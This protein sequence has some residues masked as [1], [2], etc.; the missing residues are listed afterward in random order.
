MASRAHLDHD[1]LGQVAVVTGGANGIGFG[2][3]KRLAQEGA[4]VAL[5]DMN[6]EQLQVAAERLAASGVKQNHILT[7]AVNVTHE[8]AVNAAVATVLARFGRVDIL[9]QAAGIT[10]VTGIQTHQVCVALPPSSSFRFRLRLL[11]AFPEREW[12]T[13]AEAVVRGLRE[14]RARANT[15]VGDCDVGDCDVGDCGPSVVTANGGGS[16]IHDPR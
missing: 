12:A 4:S 1:K 8:E 2:I 6:P 3:A 5:F 7:C 16:A 14:F 11:W 9:V 13:V 15:R 10:G